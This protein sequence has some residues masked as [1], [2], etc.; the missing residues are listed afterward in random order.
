MQEVKGQ[1]ELELFWM[2]TYTTNKGGEIRSIDLKRKDLLI[3]FD[4]VINRSISGQENQKLSFVT[5]NLNNYGTRVS[6][7]CVCSLEA[8]RTIELSAKVFSCHEDLFKRASLEDRQVVGVFRPKCCMVPIPLVLQPE[9]EEGKSCRINVI[10]NGVDLKASVCE[11][12]K[13]TKEQ[14]KFGM[15][16]IRSAG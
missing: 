6:N 12:K 13:M 16:W 1:V 3:S 4:A 11:V 10:H 14:L 8:A 2:G 5:K 15:E 9:W 7:Y